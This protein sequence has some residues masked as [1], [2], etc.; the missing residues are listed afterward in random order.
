MFWR[1]HRSIPF[2][3]AICKRQTTKMRVT[4][5]HCAIAISRCRS[6]RADVSTPLNCFNPFPEFH[7]IAFIVPFSFSRRVI[8]LLSFAGYSPCFLLSLAD[9]RRG[10]G[11]IGVCL[12]FGQRFLILWN[13]IANTKKYPTW[14]VQ[15]TAEP[16]QRLLITSGGEQEVFA[17]GSFGVRQRNDYDCQT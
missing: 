17:Q 2:G 16:N 13:H 9:L 7:L 15:C 3:F 1:C 8:L 11:Q 14:Q 4:S 6:C 5:F 12:Q 10:A